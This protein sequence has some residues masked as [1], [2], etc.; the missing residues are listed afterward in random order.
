MMVTCEQ[1]KL[2]E[3]RLF[4]T[5]VVA[6]DLMEKAGKACAQ[7][8][9]QF[10][11]TAGSATLYVGKGNNGGDALVVG[12]E[13]LKTGWRVDMVLSGE[14]SQMTSLAAK[15]LGE[16]E[17]QVARGFS[18]V[19]P[20][21]GGCA[22]IVVD[23]LLG[24]G[25]RGPL[26]GII[27]E[28]S[29]QLAHQRTGSSAVCFAIDIPSGVDGDLGIPYP[30]AVV[31][32]FTLSIA[33]IKGG[34]V[35]DAA[36]DHVGRIVQIA[37][38][39]IEFGEFAGEAQVLNS[40]LLAPL[41]QR[42][43]FA[44]HK[45]RAGRVSILAGSRG[46]TGA[47]ALASMAALH[48]GAGLVTLYVEPA[49]YDIVAIT[50]AAEVMVKP[51]ASIADIA[52]DGAD[53]LALGPGLGDATFVPDLLPWILNEARPMVVDADALNLLARSDGALSRLAE[54]GKAR[55]LTPH[56]GEMLRLFSGASTC[57]D[58]LEVV[59]QF[60]EQYDFQGVL[61]YKGA[62]TLVAATGQK[63]AI[64]ST[65]HPGMATGGVGDVLTGLCAALIAQGYSLYDAAC[66]GSWLIGRS[67]ERAVYDGG[68]SAE[69]LTAG[70]I[71][72]GLGGAFE[73]LRRRVF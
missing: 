41:L 21:Q 5:G 38:P 71:A 27:A 1:M 17:Q 7:A 39:E 53:V 36:I 22:S 62:R 4:A 12:R 70:M 59:Q 67:A 48:G 42:R 58:R 3:D 44:F 51:L 40:S 24:I 33:A 45:G 25:A 73:D 43:D 69:S 61:L 29:A 37:L 28:R 11:P 2:A 20:S 72:S 54:H 10:F 31:A 55:L 63:T 47:A 46:L 18:A 50:A 57:V 32:D 16:F 19:Q 6:E 49:I 56:P 23:G 66:L 26:R 60:I 8:I 52:G 34:I 35:K 30:G 68:E 13:L 64:N 14:S 9:R 15:K 65:G